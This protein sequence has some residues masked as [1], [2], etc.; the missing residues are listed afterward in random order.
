MASR[1]GPSDADRPNILID[2]CFRPVELVYGAGLLGR[3]GEIG[4]LVWVRDE[5]I[6]EDG[7]AEVAPE[8]DYI[9]GGWWRYGS[10]A[11]LPRLKAFIETGGTLPTP[12]AFDYSQALKRGI[13]VLSCSPAFT[14]FV[15]EMALT[16]ALNL[17][18]Q[19]ARVDRE[20]RAG[21]EPWSHSEFRGEFSLYGQEVGFIGFGNIGLR[22]RDL[23]APFGVRIAAFDPYLTA[24]QVRARGGEPVTLP[25]VL[26]RRIVFVLAA[27]NAGNEAMIGRELLEALRP[28]QIL[29]LMS[30][31]HVVDFEALTELLVAGRFWAGVDVFPE[32]PLPADHP[33]RGADQ[34]FLTS[35]RAGTHFQAVRAIGEMVVRDLE[36]MIGGL[37][38]RELQPAD[39][40]RLGRPSA[41]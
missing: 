39:L 14:P 23:L 36:A 19:A 28:D 34:A 41:T 13:R 16:H 22:L 10:L 4:E 35:H 38:P 27:P 24:D 25:E 18:R 32:E 12:D 31:S 1:L 15:A 8:I 9:C 6:P 11:G 37:E 3:L 17:A 21:S 7:L 2:P 5:P 20:F 29:I 40:I 33:I 26:T 30:R